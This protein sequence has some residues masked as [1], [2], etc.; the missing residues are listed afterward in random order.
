MAAQAMDPPGNTP[1]NRICSVTL[2]FPMKTADILLITGTVLLGGGTL[3]S[4]FVGDGVGAM[5]GETLS[6][7]KVCGAL[8]AAS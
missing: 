8:N 4:G 5:V 3:S 1:V 2:L 7:W 6:V